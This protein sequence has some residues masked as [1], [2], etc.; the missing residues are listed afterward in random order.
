VNLGFH[1]YAI[2]GILL[3]CPEGEEFTRRLGETKTVVVDSCNGD[4]VF[5]KLS[6]T[7]VDFCD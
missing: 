5:G 2:V 7:I 3:D 1:E 4:K 6:E